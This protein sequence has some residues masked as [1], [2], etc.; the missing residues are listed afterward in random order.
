[1]AYFPNASCPAVN[2]FNQQCATCVY[3]EDCPI[4]LAHLVYNYDQCAKDQEKLKEVLT[5]L[6]DNE[7]NCFFYTKKEEEND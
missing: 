4:L 3:E 7:G 5:W 1:M 6:V 2:R